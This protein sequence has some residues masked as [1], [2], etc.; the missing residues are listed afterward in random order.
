MAYQYRRTTKSGTYVYECESFRDKV[1]GKVV[2]K[3]VC[4]GKIDP[5]T[6]ELVINSKSD[7]P[8]IIKD[9]GAYLILDQAANQTKMITALKASFP[10]DWIDILTCAMFMSGNERALYKCEQYCETAIVPSNKPLK[11][12][13][14]S[15]LLRRIS[16][17]GRNN[18][19]KLWNASHLSNE[20]YAL[21]ITS[22]SSYSNLVDYFEWGYNRDGEALPQVNLMY[23]VGEDNKIPLYYEAFNGSITDSKTLEN[24][25]VSASEFGI[26]AIKLVMDK[27]F[28]STSNIKTLFDEGAIFC[29][30]VPFT[31]NFPKAIV[32]KVKNDLISPKKYLYNHECYADS[33]IYE[34][35][36][37]K[38][39]V[40]VFFDEVLCANEKKKV[41]EQVEKA[42]NLLS[43]LRT[44][45]E[46]DLALLKAE[47]E[48]SLKKKSREN[49]DQ[50]LNEQKNIL[51]HELYKAIKK[52]ESCFDIV[53]SNN[54]FTHTR[55]SEK[56]NE[57][58]KY[59]GYLAIITNDFSKTSEK[60]LDIYR[61][62]DVVEKKFNDIKNAIDSDRL[63][64]HSSEV[65]DGKL[66]IIFLST[67]LINYIRKIIRGN[68]ALEKYSLELLLKEAN[69]L[70]IIKYA[71]GT[72]K[73][74]VISSKQREI[75]SAFSLSETYIKKQALEL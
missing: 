19:F 65:L 35:N 2:T 3:Q 9:L 54:S 38:A 59:K 61:E 52:H 64:V 16:L 71:S 36:G 25:F 51:R 5:T 49:L 62:K 58:T 4:I 66:F 57:L 47:Y 74:N 69:K 20:Y 23:L 42:D 1:T 63:G 46:S 44:R 6:N 13:Y 68:K 26:K 60:V 15:R 39:K 43:A 53:Y 31:S 73:L 55:N 18:F 28:Y 8:D 56:I 75:F 67:I 12:Q 17:S 50:W 32:D 37:K 14:L 41:Y 29:I 22:I 70:K 34:N 33:Y 10:D 24:F 48:R 30:S 21:D 27:G 11:S 40:H 7:N 72:K 45:Y